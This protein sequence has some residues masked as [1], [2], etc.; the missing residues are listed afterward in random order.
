MPN[1]RRYTE[2]TAKTAGN[3]VIQDAIMESRAS[4]IDVTE[5]RLGWPQLAD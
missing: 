4:G 1:D 3:R 2:I 5:E